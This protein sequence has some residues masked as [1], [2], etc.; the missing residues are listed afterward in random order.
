MNITP[1]EEELTYA[2][3]KKMGI[4][5]VDKI[6]GFTGVM[7]AYT[8]HITGCNQCFLL[9]KVDKDGKKA[10]GGWFDEQRLDWA[11]EPSAVKL[12]EN[13]PPGASEG[14]TTPGRRV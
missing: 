12:D 2:L 1:I 6:T 4:V 8:V 7:T 3:N 10:E 13:K 9:P 5:G 14:A 11:E